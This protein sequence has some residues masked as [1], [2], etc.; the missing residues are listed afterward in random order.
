MGNPEEVVFCLGKKNELIYTALGLVVG[1]GLSSSRVWAVCWN[2]ELKF[3]RGQACWTYA[4]N[5]HPNHYEGLDEICWKQVSNIHSD[6]CSFLVILKEHIWLQ[7]EV[8]RYGNL[9]LPLLEMWQTGITAIRLLNP[10][11]TSH[12]IGLWTPTGYTDKFSQP[13]ITT[14]PHQGNRRPI[15]LLW[16]LRDFWENRTLL[17]PHSQLYGGIIG[18]QKTKNQKT[19]TQKN[20]HIILVYNLM[21]SLD[22][23]THSCYHHHNPGNT[24][25]NCLQKFP[26]VPVPPFFFFSFLW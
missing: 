9:R 25:M 4:F 15:S 23:R 17:F 20:L 14:G 1:D 5:N 11:G 13:Y 8:S 26:Y 2:E 10:L 6:L 21:V 7:R 19:H 16:Q 3:K 12:C 18:I 22:I 24:H